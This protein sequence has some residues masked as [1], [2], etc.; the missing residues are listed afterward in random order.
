MTRDEARRLLEE[1]TLRWASDPDSDVVWAGDH[2][3]RWGIR[4]AQRTRDFTTMWFDVGDRTV[5]FEAYLLP[6]PP[7]G[8]GEVYR[9]C[10]ARNWTAW[11]ATIAV[12]RDGDLYVR[13]RVP[14]DGLDEETLDRAVGATYQLIEVTFRPLVDIGFRRERET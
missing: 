1:T 12:D 2:E 14:L 6:M 13:G 10:L 9:L 7:H 11:P 8:F 3:G 4:M 5:G